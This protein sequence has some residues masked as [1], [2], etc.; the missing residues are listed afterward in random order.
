MNTYSVKFAMNKGT[1]N[2]I[3]IFHI[4]FKW[5]YALWNL[6]WTKA[7]R[8]KYEILHIKFKWLCTVLNLL[9]TSAQRINNYM[10][11]NFLAFLSSILV[12]ISCS[13]FLFRIQNSCSKFIILV[14]NSK[15]L[16]RIFVQISCSEFMFRIL[17]QNSKWKLRYFTLRLN[18]YT[19]CEF[20][21]WTSAQGI[22]N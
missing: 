13:E 11:M 12:Q 17:V 10:V 6:L 22:K 4:K 8:I 14:K 5:L 20:L 9:R 19:L 2:Q 3:Q 15:F 21:L 16:F 1:K 7:Q 18:N